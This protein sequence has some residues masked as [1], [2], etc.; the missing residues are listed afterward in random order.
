[1]SVLERPMA[2]IRWRRDHGHFYNGEGLSS[3]TTQASRVEDFQDL[4]A[5]PAPSR[6]TKS[7]TPTTNLP[8][9]ANSA[10]EGENQKKRKANNET[11]SKAGKFEEKRIKAIGEEDG[12]S[13]ITR[14]EETE[15]WKQNSKASEEVKKSEYIHVRARRGQAT[16]SHSLAERARREKISERMKC[17]QNLVPGCDRIAGKAGMLDEI[18]NY[19]Q[20]L[21]QQVEFLSMKLAALNPT[22][23]FI[24]VDHQFAKQVLPTAEISPETANSSSY[25]D[26]LGI[27]SS[28]VTIPQT[29]LMNSDSFGRLE[30][31]STWG[32]DL[33]SL[34]SMAFE[35]AWPPLLSPP[36]FQLPQ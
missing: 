3:V 5:S 7:E 17:L 24:N 15:T 28:S 27:C 11:K 14:T 16:D 4:V 25:Y 30:L 29:P 1:M 21:Q 34:H 8:L 2:C 31:S 6:L 10:A 33:Q 19:V 12:E 9:K 36:S 18:I 20:S 32:D 26:Q 22:L 13:K 23:E 35:Q